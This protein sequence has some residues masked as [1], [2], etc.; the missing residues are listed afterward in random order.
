MERAPGQNRRNRSQDK[1]IGNIIVER[2]GG[3]T[4]MVSALPQR[5]AQEEPPGVRRLLEFEDFPY[6]EH[7]Y[8]RARPPFVGG[9]P[10]RPVLLDFLGASC[11]M[12]N[13]LVRHLS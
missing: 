4:V 6:D 3:V 10:K 5:C 8:R 12:F 13:R 1:R 2:V 11:F 9:G 7:N